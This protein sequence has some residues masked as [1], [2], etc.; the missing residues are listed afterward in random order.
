[1]NKS[2]LIASALV[3]GSSSVAMAD[4][5]SFGARASVSWGTRAPVVVR[6]HRTPT[7]QAPAYQAPYATPSRYTNDIRWDRQRTRPAIPAGLDCR[8]W[9]PTIDVSDACAD[10]FS[11]GY[12][13]VYQPR[14]HGGWTLLGVR[15]SAV[16]DNQF[17]TVNDGR[18]FG[19]LKL[20]AETG[21]PIVTKVAVRFTDNS[22]QV[23]NVGGYLRNATLR[24]SHKAIN[25]IVV[26][27]AAGS[28]GTYSIAAL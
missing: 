10:F 4:S 8:N 22:V 7:Y 3:L 15:E 12:G 9:D 23:I 2:I 11:A 28:Q 19:T 21:N 1:M 13:Q 17:V 16:A 20:R 18:G 25:Q 6:D 26:Y 27:T 14:M 5:F 24:L